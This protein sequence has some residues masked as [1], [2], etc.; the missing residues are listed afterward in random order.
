MLVVNNSFVDYFASLC[1]R[2]EEDDVQVLFNCIDYAS[3]SEYN[4]IKAMYESFLSEYSS[5]TFNLISCNNKSCLKLPLPDQLCLKLKRKDYI[6]YKL[7]IKL[8]Y[9]WNENVILSFDN[10][11]LILN[12]VNVIDVDCNL[13]CL[14]TISFKSKDSMFVYKINKRK[15]D[16]VLVGVDDF[17]FL[18]N[19]RNSTLDQ[20]TGKVNFNKSNFI[21]WEKYINFL[22]NYANLLFVIAP[23]K[24]RI[25]SKYLPINIKTS[26][27]SQLIDYFKEKSIIDP[28]NIL[29]ADKESY[30]KTD[31]HWNYKGAFNVL[32]YTLNLWNLKINEN[33]VNFI[34]IPK[35]GDLGSKFYPNRISDTYFVEYKDFIM[36]DYLVFSNYL[37]Q[38]GHFS[39]YNNSLA[40]I[41]KTIVLFGDSFSRFW[42]P[43]LVKTF[44][45]CIF[46][47]TAGTL[48]LDLI[49]YFRP[50]YILIERAERFLL[51]PPDII[52]N[53][54]D[55]QFFYKEPSPEL[56]HNISKFKQNTNNHFINEY[57]KTYS[58]KFNI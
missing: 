38:D 41:K 40:N 46:V 1:N 45:N 53:F 18:K 49:S 9:T 3:S 58:S 19:D 47:R 12:S 8:P 15:I 4:N 51:N 34:K 42:Y 54:S 57:I 20:L 21:E 24:E 35:N 29:I 30:S 33:D 7:K 52:N 36:D 5:F 14:R 50:D 37:T 6:K 28:Y 48:I 44:E 23:S 56:K 16:N 25:Y 43:F 31:T 32:K 39:I 10:D 27:A 2:S 22:K 55:Y 26:L 17:L 11:S 13:G